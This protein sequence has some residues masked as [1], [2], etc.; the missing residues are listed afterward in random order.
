LRKD[1]LR[2]GKRGEEVRALFKLRCE[3]L[4]E[5][6]KYWVEEHRKKYIFCDKG[7]DNLKHYIEECLEIKEK[8][9]KLG[10][11]KEEILLGNCV[12]RS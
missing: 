4:E 3:N 7:K 11:D 10:K 2:K 12:M 1:N 6:N 8:F 9:T 5:G